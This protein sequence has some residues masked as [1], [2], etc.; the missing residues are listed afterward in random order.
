MGITTRQFGQYA[1]GSRLTTAEMDE[2]FNYLNDSKQAY[3]VAATGTVISF[4]APQV[5][6]TATAP[7][8]GNITNTLTNAR[9]GVVQK[10]YHNHTIAP[11][12]PAGWVLVG[13]GFYVPGVL[14]IISAEWVEG[15]RVEYW[16]T[17]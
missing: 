2:N 7:A 5:Y 9:I 17:Q 15:T 13:E 16:V 14:N 12:T 6:N 8:T 3:T 11:S 10:I 1:K 4:V